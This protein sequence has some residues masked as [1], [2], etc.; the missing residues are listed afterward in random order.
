DR[1]AT[2]KVAAFAPT[3]GHVLLLASNHTLM[4][5]GQFSVVRRLLGKPVLF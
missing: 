3:L 5:A 4:H 2:G 1:P